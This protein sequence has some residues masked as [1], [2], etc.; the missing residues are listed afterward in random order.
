MLYGSLSNLK[1]SAVRSYNS[2]GKMLALKS[3]NSGKFTGILQTQQPKPKFVFFPLQMIMQH[4]TFF[5]NK[6]TPLQNLLVLR[7]ECFLPDKTHL[8]VRKLA[9]PTRRHWAILATMQCLPV[10]PFS[11]LTFSICTSPII[12]LVGK[13]KFCITLGFV[14]HF[15]WVLKS[16]Q[17]KLKT[18]LMQRF[19]GGQT[20]LII[21]DVQMVNC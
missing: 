13:P 2:I 5:W 9:P 17:E 10:M 15:A 18:L 1:K 4:H 12:H 11:F 3:F 7:A 6:H 14:F 19:G 8:N 21:G 16:S 20:R